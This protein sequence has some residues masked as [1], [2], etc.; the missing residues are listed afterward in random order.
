MNRDARVEFVVL[1]RIRGEWQQRNR[2]ILW[3][4]RRIDAQRH[5]RNCQRLC[6]GLNSGQA[7]AEDEPQ[8]TNP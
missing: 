5:F 1:A 6:L 8:Y 4:L 7:G 3:V 2:D